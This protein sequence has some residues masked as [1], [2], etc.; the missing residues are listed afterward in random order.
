MFPQKSHGD[1]REGWIGVTRKVVGYMDGVCRAIFS[2]SSLVFPSWVAA[3]IESLNAK[4]CHFAAQCGTTLPTTRNLRSNLEVRDPKK[5]AHV[6][7]HLNHGKSVAEKSYRAVE[8]SKRA[9]VFSVVL[10]LFDI[11]TNPPP[12]TKRL[13]TNC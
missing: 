8:A 13:K 9:E 7:C 10:D 12:K 11:K 5:Q 1:V 6:A 3:D 4:V 2:R